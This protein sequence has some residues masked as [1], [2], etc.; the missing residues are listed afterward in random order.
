MSEI[1]KSI[2]YFVILLIMTLLPGINAEA[3]PDLKNII[4]ISVDTLRADHMGC[5][6][7]PLNTSPSVD[8]FAHD[9]VLFARC[10]SPT[11]LTS[12]AFTT[13]LTSLPPHKHGAKRN[14]LSIFNKINTLP[15]YLKRFGYRSAAVIS[16]WTLRKRLSG[17]HKDF[18]VYYQVFTKKRW[19]GIKDAEGTAPKVT[20]KAI[21]WIENNRKKRFFIWVH[22]TEPHAPYISH[23]GFTFDYKNVPASTYPPGTRMKKIEK[24][25]SE[26]AFTDFHI[27]KLIEKIKELGLY[28]N[29][30]IIFN[31]DHGES[32]GEHNYF[33]HGSKLYNSTLHVPMI[34]KL[35]GN[36]LKGTVRKENVSLM[37]IPPTISS[38][39]NMPR[40]PKMEGLPLFKENENNSLLERELLLETYGGKVRFRRKG[41]KHQMKI[42]PIK[43]ATLKGSRKV[44]YNVKAKTFETYDLSKDF[45]ETENIFLRLAMSG[46]EIKERLLEK[47]VVITEYIK[48]SRKHRLHDPTISK[49]D[50]EKLKSMGYLE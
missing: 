5:Y 42:K 2:R 34:V 19:L 25:D 45:F 23:K 17:L 18:D 3:T 38:A 46:K 21:E 50:M 4:I 12:P 31:G 16:N 22:Y 44:I 26:I 32:F 7:Y 37:D 35:P 49:E 33:R 39:L 30:L 8:A 24:Y 13:M 36:Q 20:E 15:Y 1:N 41:K 28:E 6:G 48:L 9:S 10:Y 11:P 43:Y 29:S 14:G 40:F 27:G 47:V